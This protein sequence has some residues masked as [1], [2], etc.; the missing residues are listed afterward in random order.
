MTRDREN[1]PALQLIGIDFTDLSQLAGVVLG[2]RLHAFVHNVTTAAPGP[3]QPCAVTDVTGQGVTSNPASAIAT[4]I[5]T[6]ALTAV[7]RARRQRF[8]KR[9]F[10]ALP[11]HLL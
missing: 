2:H 3:G 9:I 1:G 10:R 11:R 8:L 5:A 7:T 6:L 4:T